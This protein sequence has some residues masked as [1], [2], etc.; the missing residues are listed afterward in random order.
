LEQYI[1][2]YKKHTMIKVSDYIFSYLKSKGTD[3]IFSVA[4]GAA[5]HLL[6]SVANGDYTYICNYHEQACAMAA[7]GYAR[8]ANKPA[9]VLVTNGPGSSNTITGVL[10]AYQDSIPMIVISGQVPVAQSLGSLSDVKLRQLGV[11]ECDI[12]SMVASITKYSVQVTDAQDIQYHL[13]RA[14]HEATTGRPG[15]VWLD[16]P[17]DIQSAVVDLSTQVEFISEQDNKPVIDYADIIALLANA[18]RPLVVTGNGIHLAKSEELFNKII[19][20]GADKLTDDDKD[21]DKDLDVDIDLDKD[22]DK[23]LD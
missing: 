4:G 7:E 17:L 21:L 1:E 12:I 8:I 23:D 9:I 5:A 2:L 16:I 22:L 18:E 13:Q 10:G 20:K 19:E 14:Y 11:Q 6:N 15:P 3:T